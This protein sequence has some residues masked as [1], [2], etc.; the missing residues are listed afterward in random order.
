MNYLNEDQ[1]NE[2][3]TMLSK[4]NNLQGFQGG[5]IDDFYGNQVSWECYYDEDAFLKALTEQNDIIGFT[6]NKFHL[7]GMIYK[8]DHIDVSLYKIK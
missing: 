7:I 5:F 4:C 6:H 3:L 8:E 2:L 1:T